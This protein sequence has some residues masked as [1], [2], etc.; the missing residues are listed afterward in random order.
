[1]LR[2]R[3]AYACGGHGAVFCGVRIIAGL[4]ALYGVEI[5]S[6]LRRRLSAHTGSIRSP[7]GLQAKNDNYRR[8]NVARGD[9]QL[10]MRR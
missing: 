8:I 2:E 4:Q 3:N 7:V 9:I 5:T 1:M 10:G 6:V